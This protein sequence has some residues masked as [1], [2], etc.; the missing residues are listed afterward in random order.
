LNDTEEL[1]ARAPHWLTEGNPGRLEQDMRVLCM[2]EPR[3]VRAHFLHGVALHLLGRIDDAL[4]VFETTLVLDPRH[5]QAHSAR[6]GMLH[7]LGDPAAAEQGYLAALAIAPQDAETLTNLARVREDLGRDD[8]ALAGYERALALQPNSVRALQNRAALLARAGRVVQAQQAC[9]ALLQI[10]PR[11]AAAHASLAN[12]L[13][14]QLLFD[15]ALQSASEALRLDPEHARA[16][17]DRALALA[18]L[19]RFDEYAAAARRA[20]A[21]QEGILRVS[22]GDDPGPAIPDP[23]VIYL[24]TAHQRLTRADWHDFQRHAEV[25]T[26]L[27]RDDAL[28]ATLPDLL[29]L[30]FLSYVW[31]VPP[32]ARARLAR[33]CAARVRVRAVPRVWV[34]D[35]PRDEYR[36]RIGY[37]SCDFRNHPGARALLQVLRRHDRERFHVTAFVLNRDDG[38]ELRRHMLQAVDAVVPLADL[39]DHE[40]AWRVRKHGCD[41]LVYRDGYTHGT[42]PGILAQH[43]APLQLNWAGYHGTLGGGLAEYHISEP[44]SDPPADSALWE[45]ARLFLPHGPI[46]YPHPG[47]APPATPPPRQGLGLPAGGIVFAAMHRAEKIDPALFACWMDLLHDVPAAVLWLL[48]GAPELPA[49]LRAHARAHGIGGERLVF[50]PLAE[51]GAHLDRLAAADIWLDTRWYGSHTTMLD[52]L[53]AGVPAISCMGNAVQGRI[54]GAILH[55][56]GLP[57][58]VCTTLDEYRRIGG[59]LAREAS[60][61][62]AMRAHLLRREAP[63]FDVLAYVRALEAGYEQIWQRHRSGLPPCDLHVGAQ[64][65][66]SSR[67]PP[68]GSLSPPA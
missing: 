49:A 51:S 46:I 25:F 41:L 28:A 61:R 7:R 27:A 29:G 37:L 5:V 32:E 40:A 12:L 16:Q 35:A 4:A 26:D 65:Y 2:R 31:P 10:A 55:S 22:D 48:D 3:N 1:L 45:E 52:A 33:R 66:P 19:G 56:A 20:H 15:E 53:A 6:A 38:S 67:P 36:L 50:A 62:A 8:L 24:I 64:A 17:A 44:I 18:A 30:L 42:R 14:A 43:P 59:R 60:T 23:R 34:S 54:G 39:D 57:E 11:L 9:R 21:L 13:L 58:L 68:I 63:I 47:Y